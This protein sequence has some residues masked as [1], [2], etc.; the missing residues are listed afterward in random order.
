SGT[1]SGPEPHQL[2]AML[3]ITE[4]GKKPLTLS[5]GEQRVFLEDGDQVTMRGWCASKDA[6]RI[7]F[8]ECIGKISH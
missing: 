4:G 6:A 2:A 7:G 1:L 5:N 3:E 8:G